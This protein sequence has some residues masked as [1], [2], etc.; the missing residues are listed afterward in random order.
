M[1][2]NQHQITR[3]EI[4]GKNGREC[5]KYGAFSFSVQDDGKTLKIF[6]D[7]EEAPQR[8]MSND[9]ALKKIAKKALSKIY[10]T[11]NK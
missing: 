11:N 9:N 6:V 5:V 8:L 3:V 10:L 2:I 1:Q 7:K 4:I